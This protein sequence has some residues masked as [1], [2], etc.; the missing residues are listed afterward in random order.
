ME[1]S[2]KILKKALEVKEELGDKTGIAMTSGNI[3]EVYLNLKQYEQ[4]HIYLLKSYKIS[5]ELGDNEGVIQSTFSIS[6]YYNKK[7]NADSAIYYCE[8]ALSRANE[9]G[10]LKFKKDAYELLS[11][12]YEND[13]KFEKALINYKQ[14]YA[15]A[16]SI[17][18]KNNSDKLAELQAK[19][20]SDKKEKEIELLNKTQIINEAELKKRMVLNYAFIVS[21]IFIVVIFLILFNRYRIKKKANDSLTYQN[22]IIEKHKEELISQKA[23][24]SKVNDELRHKNSLITDSLNYAKKIQDAILPS[25]ESVQCIFPNF[26]IL[27]RPKDIV[28]GDFYWYAF[29]NNTAYFAV[30]D[31]TGHG[32]PGAFMSMIGNTL[33]N[34][35][36]NENTFSTPAQILE[37]LNTRVIKALSQY[38]STPTYQNDGMDISLFSYNK[39]IN[40]IQLAC[41]NQM[42]YII[43]DEKITVIDGDVYSIGGGIGNHPNAV[44]TNHLIHLTKKTCLYI[45][46]DGYYDQ[47]GGAENKKFMVSKF[48]ELILQ[49][50]SKPMT[51]QEKIFAQ[52]IQAW[53][54]NKKQTDD[55]LL[56]GFEL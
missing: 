12:I 51:E 21:I 52:T 32:V 50:H 22:L 9:T 48:K 55:I 47:F 54:G 6:N 16:D 41:V 56:A 17:F 19:Y 2:E 35:I 10:N 36:I 26:F 39:K 34:D 8:L 46:T 44:F 31:C 30:V 23:L 37:I 15:F 13:K 27:Y 11:A 53:K 45:S 7:G 28:S 24:L 49:N 40:E 3:G 4:A 33:L 42:A 38:S 25:K 14:Y 29:K 18:N 43:E 5:K 1:E 20:E